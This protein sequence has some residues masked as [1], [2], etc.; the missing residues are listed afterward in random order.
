MMS[1]CLLVSTLTTGIGYSF[2][3]HVKSNRIVASEPQASVNLAF[4]LFDFGSFEC[5][6]YFE[7]LVYII[8]Y[9]RGKLNPTSLYGFFSIFEDTIVHRC[10]IVCLFFY[11]V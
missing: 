11:F 3:K 10:N 8:V 5:G 2:T 4:F 6:V 1:V 9:I 7:E